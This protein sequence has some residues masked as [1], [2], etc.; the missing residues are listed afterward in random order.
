MLPALLAAAAMT[1]ALASTPCPADLS[2]AEPRL[3]VVRA[4]DRAMDNYVV[5]VN[6]K[7]RGNG[8]QTPDVEQHLELLREG[9]VIGSQPI[10][11]LGPNQEYIAAFRL[12]LPHA[13]KRPPFTVTFHYVLDSKGQAAR[14]NCSSANDRL[15]VTL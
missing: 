15:T 4:A 11:P 13:S 6:V 2:L 12:Q 10:P 8:G 1:T 7:N 5:T 3:K 9:A 14:N